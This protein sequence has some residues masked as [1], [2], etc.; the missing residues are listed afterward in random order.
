[1]IRAIKLAP[2][3]LIAAIVLVPHYVWRL[4]GL[5]VLGVVGLVL[6]VAVVRFLIAPV[7]VKANYP[8]AIWARIRWRSH[9]RN[10]ALARRDIHVQDK[11]KRPTIRPPVQHLRA[12]FKPTTH[13]LAL[14]VRTIP[15]TGRAEFEAAAD[16]LA[17]A[18]RCQR[19][20]ISQ[21]RPGRL[22][23]RGLKRD[24]LAD[25]L[26]VTAA[27]VGTY[28]QADI[29]RPYLGLD[30]HA[31]HRYLSLANTT[32]MVIGGL[33]GR[34]KSVLIN[35]L[36][37]QW[38]GSPKV[39]L[40][41]LDGKGSCDFEAWRPRCWLMSGDDLPAAVGVLEDIHLEMRRRLGRIREL[42]GSS[43]G[44]RSGP[45]EDLPALIVLVD[46]CQVFL[47][48]AAVKGR[49][50]DED[51]VRRCQSLTAELVRKG[52]SAMVFV[53]LATQKATTDSLPSSIRDNAGLSMCFAVK[54]SEA[55]AAVLGASIREYPSFS[56]LGLQDDAY[57]GVAVT[58]MATGNDPF[59]RVRIPDVSED[60]V[61]QRA[62]ETAHLRVDPAVTK[63]VSVPEP[64]LEGAR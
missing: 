62:I 19:V 38:A 6:V 61:I 3:I 25:M 56:P 44:W 35:S 16:H 63:R 52:R 23:L 55:A 24:P 10:L 13:G 2:L 20:S 32:G 60:M 18:W 1:M 17:N 30:E 58:T 31:Q 45:S 9:A 36:L 42:S 7:A 21:P 26:P 28:V 11:G 46:E 22:V 50:P 57:A 33:P 12:R 29:A 53:V 54:T 40:A 59:T 5:A 4:S 49:K 39:A 15:G 47:D 48:S 51:L 8:A 34:G 14:S 37:C 43:N 41:L 64:V 27:P